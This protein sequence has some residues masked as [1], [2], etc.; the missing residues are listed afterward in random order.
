M[1]GYT[2]SRRAPSTTR[3]IFQIYS[4]V[5]L[6][7]SFT[8]FSALDF[9]SNFAFSQNFIQKNKITQ[10]NGKNKSNHKKATQA[11]A[12]D[13]SNLIE[14][15]QPLYLYATTMHIKYDKKI[16]TQYKIRDNN[17]FILIK[18]RDKKFF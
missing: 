1:N 15:K 13:H 2:C 10:I 18:D 11:G 14:H 17:F 5:F 8:F 7:S 16:A 4:T 9:S 12:D 6:F 3:P